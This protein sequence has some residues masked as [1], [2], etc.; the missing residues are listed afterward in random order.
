MEKILLLNPKED[1][2]IALNS[3][4]VSDGKFVIQVDAP[5]H[6]SRQVV[7][8]AKSDVL[9]NPRTSFSFA[10]DSAARAGQV[11]G[12]TVKGCNLELAPITLKTG[13]FFA[14]ETGISDTP[15]ETWSIPPGACGEVPLSFVP[16]SPVENLTFKI[17]V[18]SGSNTLAE[19]PASVPVLPALDTNGS[20]AS[21]GP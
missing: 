10:Y 5:Y 3:E 16:I 14:P 1:H 17:R 7:I 21:G 11:F 4:W 2:T 9:N 6:L 13:L 19:L 20:G 8:Q 15:I 12:V 18:L